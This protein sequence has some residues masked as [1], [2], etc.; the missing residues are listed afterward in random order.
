MSTYFAMGGYAAYVWTAYILVAAVLAGLWI[1]SVRTLKAREA[2]LERAEAAS[3]RR[4]R[5]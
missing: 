4:S 2:D 5:P 3:P 1:A